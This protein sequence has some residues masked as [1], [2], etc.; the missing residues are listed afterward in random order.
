MSTKTMSKAD[1]LEGYKRLQSGAQTARSRA[2]ANKDEIKV[3]VST[4]IG[5][6]GAGYLDA[7]QQ[8]LV[9]EG[10]ENP[11]K[12]VENVPTEG[13]IGA[14][15]VLY[16]V[17]GKKGS[18]MRKYALGAGSGALAYSVGNMVRDSQLETAA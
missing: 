5:G 3:A 10:K 8:K 4:V 7:Y 18:K 15:M 14:G 16:G 12:L 6:A 9:N 2:A 17:F 1:L 11:L 13:I